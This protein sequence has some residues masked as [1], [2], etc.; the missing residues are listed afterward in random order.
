MAPPTDYN[1]LEH[2]GVTIV[3]LELESL[4]GL[5][6]VTRLE[7]ELAALVDGG[8]R[9]LVLDFKHVRYAA[10]AALGMMMSLQ[11]RL[12]A[13]GGKLVLSRTEHIDQLLKVAKARHLFQI[14]PDPKSAVAMLKE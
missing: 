8:V 5:I 6:D 1:L 2:E 11:K 12:A 14:A 3:R 10:S 13:V 4:V 9:K 7:A